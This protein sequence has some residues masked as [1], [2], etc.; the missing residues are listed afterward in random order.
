[1]SVAATDRLE[2]RLSNETAFNEWAH[3]YDKGANPLVALEERFLKGLMPSIEGKDVL[4]VGCGTG[5]W[6]ERLCHFDTA[7]SLCGVDS[8]AEMLAVAGRKQLAGASLLQAQLPHLPM[9]S[10][11][12]DVAL[13]SFVLSYVPDIQLC[14]K[15]LARVLRVDGELIITDMHPETAAALGWQRSFRSSRGAVCLENQQHSVEAIIAA[16][17]GQ[18]LRLAALYEPSFGEAERSIFLAQGKE[19]MYRKADGRSAIYIIHFVR[20]STEKAPPDVVVTGANCVLGAEAAVTARVEIRQGYVALI[21]PDNSNSHALHEIDLSGYRVFPG[22]INAHDHLEFALFPELSAAPYNN[23]TEWALDIQQ[24]FDKEIHL[25]TQVP[26]EVRLWWGALRNLLCGVTTVCH[27]NPPHPVFRDERFPVNVIQDFGWAHSLSFA[28]DLQGAHRGADPSKPFIIHACEGID[29]DA[30]S[31]FRRLE[32]LD[33]IDERSVLVHGLA[34]SPDDIEVLNRRGAAIITC[35]SSNH[36]LFSRT[37]SEQ[38]L[39]SITKLAIGSD[40]PLTAQGDLLDEIRFCREQVG[41]SCELIYR[42]VTRRAAQVLRINQSSAGHLGPRSVA[43]VFAVRAAVHSPAQHL[44]MLSWRDVELVI[45][46]GIVRLASPA[47]LKRLP[48]KISQN[49]CCLLIDGVPRWIDAP[50]DDLFNSAAEVLGGNKLFLNGR[51]MS[52]IEK[53]YVS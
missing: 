31:E 41:L 30:A 40:S 13:A 19:S 36:R 2:H 42:S 10:T 4:D 23:A 35:P 17:E 53:K 1:M 14:A 27:H 26:K 6:L 11:S 15:E 16:M 37:L 46:R 9:N 5:R 29:T 21:S 34:M 45:V 44:T 33:V 20:T 24:R 22:L 12:I 38:Q 18:G 49:L 48:R 50:V 51:P 52:L 25:H 28:N 43:D 7:R 3:V 39:S 47:M 32:E 8:S